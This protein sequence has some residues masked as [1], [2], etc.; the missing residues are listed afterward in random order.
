[1]HVELKHDPLMVRKS[2]ISSVVNISL[3]IYYCIWDPRIR[4]WS[5]NEIYTHFPLQILKWTCERDH[6]EQ[7]HSLWGKKV[8]WRRELRLFSGVNREE[9]DRGVLL[10]EPIPYVYAKVNTRKNL[11]AVRTSPFGCWFPSC[12]GI[13]ISVTKP[14]LHN[15]EGDLGAPWGCIGKR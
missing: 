11:S 9:T 3:T 14:T 13:I 4:M 2:D 12:L 6:E 10:G 1:M 7:R 5:W 15:I 8:G